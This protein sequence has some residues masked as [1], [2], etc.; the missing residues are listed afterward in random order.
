MVWNWQLQAC[1][2]GE[3][4]C[5]QN[6]NGTWQ[7]NSW[8]GMSCNRGTPADECEFA[9]KAWDWESE[10]CFAT[11]EELFEAEA[12]RREKDCQND[13]GEWMEFVEGD[14]FLRCYTGE[15]W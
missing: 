7:E 13:G 3:D 11:W 2:T 9:G 10:Q 4:D 6:E 14:G 15:A 5:T 12:A 1:F 8:G